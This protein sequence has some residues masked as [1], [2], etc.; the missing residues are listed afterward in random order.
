VTIIKPYKFQKRAVD[1]L[2]SY[3]SDS[4]KYNEPVHLLLKAPT[5]SGKTIIM[6][7]YIAELLNIEEDSA[8]VWICERP[9]LTIQSK[10]KFEKFFN[11]P[12]EEFEDTRRKTELSGGTVSFVN[13][14]ILRSNTK[15][16]KTGDVTKSLVDLCETTKLNGRKIIFIIDEAHSSA[17]S[18][19]NISLVEECS[20]D[21]VLDVTAT[22]DKKRFI[23]FNNPSKTWDIKVEDVQEEE[24]IK[25]SIIINQSQEFYNDKNFCKQYNIDSFRDFILFQ[26]LE[27]RNKIE[28]DIY[29]YFS[30][31][32]EKYYVPLLL[33]QIPPNSKNTNDVLPEVESF[34][35]NR[36]Y[37]KDEEYAVYLSGDI[38]DTLNNIANDEKY[39][40]LIFKNAIAKGWDCPRASILTMLRDAKSEDFTIQTIGRIM[41]V[42]KL[43][44]FDNPYTHLNKGYIFL[45]TEQNKI[46]SQYAEKL[47]KEDG[48]GSIQNKVKD[49]FSKLILCIT[50]KKLNNKYPNY[51]DVYKQIYENMWFE[52]KTKEL[53]NHDSTKWKNKKEIISGEVNYKFENSKDDPNESDFISVNIDYKS[54]YVLSEKDK[55]IRYND[56]YS[57]FAMEKNI[58]TRI[59]DHLMEEYGYDEVF[60]KDLLVN[61]QSILDNRYKTLFS[62]YIKPKAV[63]YKDTFWMPETPREEL[64]GEHF[65]EIDK[66][67]FYEKCISKF[68][69]SWEKSF[70]EL[71]TEMDDI[72]F[73]IRN[74]GSGKNAYTIPYTVNY[75]YSDYSPDFIIKKG[76]I[77]WLLDTKAIIDTDEAK[78]KFL[79]AKE[80]EKNNEFI[81]TGYI[82][83]FNNSL[84]MYTGDNFVIE[85]KD[86]SKWTN[87]E[88]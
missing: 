57:T 54:D 79:A 18:K 85:E 36:G 61:N 30:E 23:F 15:G 67:Y 64:Y 69:S 28:K 70:A 47:R 10:Q 49:E 27:L 3:T 60:A 22:P 6:G 29:K 59:L 48:Y 39:K 35:Q 66:K 51:D 21:I 25:S 86:V 16:T 77:I 55:L 7:L 44:Y 63:K 20:S 26:S 53:L 88:L 82:K 37:K 9:D 5:G 62:Q 12:V 78:A 56:R 32:N 43:K 13:W 8:F 1:N 17:N 83:K 46:I 71:L 52:I 68:D 41:R 38:T 42:P 2:I 80:L 81:R 14:E 50:M 4:F 84:L 45:E 58:L 73:W 24:L 65:K 31:R 76:D 87:I 33:I 75:K 72:D 40:V 19:Q 34:L 11:F 74:K